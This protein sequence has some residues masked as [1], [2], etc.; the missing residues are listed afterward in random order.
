M[1]DT[2]RQLALTVQTLGLAHL[3]GFFDGENYWRMM[4]FI[5]RARTFEAVT[6]ES[7]YEHHHAP[8][9]LAIKKVCLRRILQSDEREHLAVYVV[10][11]G[12]FQLPYICANVTNT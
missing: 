10:L 7:G 1:T 3:V 8:I 5:P 2:F 12:C 9:I 6:A 11:A 4:V